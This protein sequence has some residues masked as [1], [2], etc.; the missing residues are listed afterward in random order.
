MLQKD[1]LGNFLDICENNNH[2]D[3]GLVAVIT[4][5]IENF[6]Q[7]KFQSFLGQLIVTANALNAYYIHTCR[8]SYIKFH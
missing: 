8:F 3:F 1:A 7:L 4:I 5:F 6:H 2:S